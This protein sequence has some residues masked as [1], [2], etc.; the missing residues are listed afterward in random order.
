M[1]TE[2]EQVIKELLRESGAL[3]IAARNLLDSKVS[4]MDNFIDP[5]QEAVNN[6]ED[7]LDRLFPLGHNRP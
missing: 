4:H 5:L 6:F 3:M 1:K 2:N 7:T